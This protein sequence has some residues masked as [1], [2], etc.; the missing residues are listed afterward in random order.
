MFTCKKIGADTA[1]NWRNLPK[2]PEVRNYPTDR[3]RQA[4][5]KSRRRRR[6]RGRGVRGVP[7]RRR[8]GRGRGRPGRV[9]VERHA[10]LLGGLPADPLFESEFQNLLLWKCTAEFHQIFSERMTRWWYWNLTYK[11]TTKFLKCYALLLED[12]SSS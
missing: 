1:E 8:R 6:R 11:M 10:A 5:P 9:D 12:P 3:K 7:R 2:F 4:N